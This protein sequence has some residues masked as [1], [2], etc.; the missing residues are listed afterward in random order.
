MELNGPEATRS[1]FRQTQIRRKLKRAGPGSEQ[2]SK[3]AKASYF[4]RFCSC[5]FSFSL[6]LTIFFT[7]PAGMRS[8]IGN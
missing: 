1:L 6:N 5:S 3:R 7:R 2:E 4:F 8:S